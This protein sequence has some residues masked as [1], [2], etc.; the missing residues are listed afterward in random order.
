MSHVRQSLQLT[1]APPCI[2]IF[3]STQRITFTP[4]E[5]YSGK[6]T[7]LDSPVHT[8][9]HR[10]LRHQDADLSRFLNMKRRRS[11]LLSRT[12]NTVNHTLLRLV[13]D[14]VF[15]RANIPSLQ[16]HASVLQLNPC[17]PPLHLL[18][19]HLSFCTSSSSLPP[20]PCLAIQHDLLRRV[21]IS[22][23]VT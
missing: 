8:E 2:K 20:N 22:T 4:T 21:S 14:S 10:T 9:L 1:P 18:F 5:T 23:L 13:C 11:F 19:S 6:K 15:V 16:N 17:L 3:H 7:R 12:N